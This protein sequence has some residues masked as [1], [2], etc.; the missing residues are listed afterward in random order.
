MTDADARL[1]PETAYDDNIDRC[2]KLLPAW[3]VPRM[4]DDNWH[5]G[6][7]LVTGQALYVEHLHDVRKAADG[8]IWLE[9]ALYDQ[10]DA[11]THLWKFK[12][13]PLVGAPTSRKRASVNLAH[14][15]FVTELADT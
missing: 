10:E 2:A 11:S 3:F 4:M 6:M 13:F 1:D 15:V 12:H 9:V 5:F 8:S 14:V 7:V